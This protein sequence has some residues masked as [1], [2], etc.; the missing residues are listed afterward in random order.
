MK[1][2]KNWTKNAENFHNVSIFFEIFTLS[3]MKTRTQMFPKM[4]K[5]DLI[6]LKHIYIGSADYDKHKKYTDLLF[7]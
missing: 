3:K 6:K 7:S 5:N 1:T 4:D 2:K